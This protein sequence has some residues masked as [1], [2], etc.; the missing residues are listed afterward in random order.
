MTGESHKYPAELLEAAEALTKLVAADTGFE[1]TLSRLAELTVHAIDGVEHCSISLV[2]SPGKEMKTMAATDGV[3]YQI[4]GLQQETGEGPCM[5]SIEDHATFVIPD[6]LEDDTWPTFS[7][8]AAQQTGIRSMLSFVLRL[9]GENTGALNLTSTEKDAFS[10]EDVE[11]GTLFAAQAAVAMAEALQ[12]RD[13][14]QKLDQ[15]EEGMKTRQMIGQAVGI[16]MAT[17]A[18]DQEAAFQ[19]LVKASQNANIKVREIAQRV[20]DKAQEL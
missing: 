19:M 1:E 18:I 20:V 5:S 8:R 7:T 15:L 6:M 10:D 14:L 13:G 16:L 3:C 11:T 17:R 9:S 12:H 2:T 4:D